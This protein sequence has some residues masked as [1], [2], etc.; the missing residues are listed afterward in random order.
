MSTVVVSVYKV[1]NFPT[2]GGHFW[3]Y[4]QY[5]QGLLALGCDVY[6]LEH[7]RDVGDPRREADLRALFLERM[8]RFGMEGKALLYKVDPDSAAPGSIDFVVGGD[9]LATAV[10]RNTDLVL[11]FH[12]AIA[13]GLLARF[14]R[15]ALV[16]IDPGLLQFWMSAGQ[17]EVP[18]HDH[19][20]TTGETV[21]TPEA[22]FPDCG[23]NWTHVRRPVCLDSWPM[24]RTPDAD[25]FTTVSGWASASY[26][27][28]TVGS[29]T[30]LIDNTKRA[31]FLEI[32]DLPGMVAPPLELALCLLDRDPAGRMRPHQAKRDATDRADLERR[33]WRVR[34]A[35]EVAGGPDEYRA[36]IQGSRGELSAAKRSCVDFQNAW[37]SDRT[38]CY[39][40]SGKPVVVR[41]TGPS[42]F[43]PDGEGMF[44]FRTTEEAAEALAKIEGDYRHHSRVARDIAETQFD[45]RSVLEEVLNVAFRAPPLASA[46]EAHR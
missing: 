8:K 4:M 15:S 38:L 14:R 44:R 11:N 32:A 27:E 29:E 7:F 5:V 36:Y 24:T 3:V 26:L 33:G 10:T 34:D 39:L 16:D 25:A 31:A 41:D 28:V 18:R 20:L 12:Y 45:A 35:W 1:A 46:A 19:Y 40:A 23:L 21:G 2:G 13:P 22:A 37:V 17:L 42:A 30:K 9:R 43:L 6:W